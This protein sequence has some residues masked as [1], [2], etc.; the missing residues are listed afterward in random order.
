MMVLRNMSQ[1]SKLHRNIN[2]PVSIEL[3]IDSIANAVAR[4]IASYLD[5]ICR[6]DEIKI[7]YEK[8][9]AFFRRKTDLRIDYD[10]V[11]ESFAC[12]YFLE[13]YWKA[14]FSFKAN[15]PLMGNNLVDFGAGSGA[16]IIAYLAWLSEIV[17]VST[18]GEWITNITLVDISNNQLLLAKEFINRIRPHLSNLFIDV[19]V[20]NKQ[21]LQVKDLSR[22]QDIVFFGHVLSENRDAL[23]QHILKGF[24]VLR[25]GGEIYIFERCSDNDI[26]IELKEIYLELGMPAVHYDISFNAKKVITGGSLHFKDKGN[27]CVSTSKVQIPNMKV[28]P[29]LVRKYFRAWRTKNIDLL[30][31]VFTED[32][33]YEDKPGLNRYE[34]LSG[35]RSYW[36]EK[37][38][39][40]RNSSVDILSIFYFHNKAHVSWEADLYNKDDSQKNVSGI[41][42]LSLRIRE[43]KLHKLKEYFIDIDT[44][45]IYQQTPNLTKLGVID[46][47]EQ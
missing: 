14:Y 7:D 45:P 22:P 41:M 17:S 6:P 20:D 44:S 35:I 15:K 25:G 31:E 23:D 39:P 47:L 9:D 26:Q 5:D 24:D 38:F 8:L 43:G 29:V 36:R 10:K 16:T 34:N 46:K 21:I 28:F 33:I 1:K 18:K 4:S 2:Y 3:P 42:E 40:Q 11:G 37:V 27:T 13:N 32:A 30:D 19:V 12:L